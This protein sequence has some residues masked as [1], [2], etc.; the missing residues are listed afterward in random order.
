MLDV[1]ASGARID[2][3]GLLETQL[4]PGAGARMILSLPPKFEA[5]PVDVRV[6]WRK[7]ETIGITFSAG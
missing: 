4:V 1:S 2:V 6:D 5:R 7:D 3:G